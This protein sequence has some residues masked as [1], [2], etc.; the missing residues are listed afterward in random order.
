MNIINYAYIIIILLIVSLDYFL[1]LKGYMNIKSI[2]LKK[3]IEKFPGVNVYVPCKDANETLSDNLTSI[4][5]QDYPRFRVFFIVG[6]KGDEAYRTIQRLIRKNNKGNLLV[7]GK[8]KTCCQKNQNLLYGIESDNKADV[9]IFFDSDHYYGKETIKKLVV[10]ITE[11]PNSISTS[12]FKIRTKDKSF[13]QIFMNSFVAYQHVLGSSLKFVWGGCMAITK[14]LF[15]KSGI[16]K[17]WKKTVTDDTS[18]VNHAKKKKIN[19]NFLA[20][21]I[22]HEP[23]KKTL[24]GVFKWVV[25][26]IMYVKYYTKVLWVGTTIKYFIKCLVIFFPIFVILFMKGPVHYYIFTWGFFMLA[27][28]LSAVIYHKINGTH[29]PIR[30]PFY[31]IIVLYIGL[32]ALIVSIF[33]NK[34]EWGGNTYLLEKSGKVKSIRFKY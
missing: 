28:M 26:H 22:I 5:K 4:L 3:N 24:Q 1:I 2:R 25:R 19:I 12:Y 8:A 11:H 29:F 20:L 33:K 21:N 31:S 23:G 13:A 16:L 32:A 9:F 17:I 6:N 7:A 27:L 14:N 10:S 30:M 34:M 18:I 15:F